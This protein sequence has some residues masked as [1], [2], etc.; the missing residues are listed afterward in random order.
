MKQPLAFL[1]SLSVFFISSAINAQPPQAPN[2]TGAGGK[3]SG[4]W[5]LWLTRNSKPTQNKDSAVY[6]REITYQDGKPSGLVTDFYLTGTKR[7][8]GYLVSDS[9]E[10][11]MSGRAVWYDKD[12]N[13]TEEAQ[14]NRIGKKISSTSFKNLTQ[15]GDTLASLTNEVII[16]NG[17]ENYTK[18][19][20]CLEEC[21]KLAE[22]KFGRQHQVYAGY[23]TLTS[24]LYQTLGSYEKAEPL[25]L[26]AWQIYKTALGENDFACALPMNNLGVLYLNAGK[27]EKAEPLFSQA[28][29]ICNEKQKTADPFYLVCLANLGLLYFEMGQYDKAEPLMLRATEAVYGDFTPNHTTVL[30]NLA[31]LYLSRGRYHEAE[32]LILKATKIARQLHGE[33]HFDYAVTLSS[34]GD[35]YQKVGRY[36]QA[37]PCFE[38]SLAITTSQLG[39]NHI[40]AA[41]QLNRLA[42]FYSYTNHNKEAVPLYERALQII[43]NLIGDT[44]TDYTIF[45][46][47][48][49]KSY[50]DMAKLENAEPLFF[51][52]NENRLNQ[53]DRYFPFLSEK[54]KEEFYQSIKDGFEE[55]LSFALLRYPGN[56]GIT[57]EMYTMQLGTK[58]LLLN[59]SAKWKQ[60]IRTSGDKKLAALYYTW[61]DK[62]AVL[63][64]LYKQ[65]DPKKKPA[66][67]SL[68]RDVNELEKELSRR[69]E[70][71]AQY[72][73]KHHYTWRD[74][75]QKLMPGEAAI[76]ILRIRKYGVTKIVTDSSDASFPRYPKRGI[77]DTVQYAALVLKPGS[78]QPEL[79]VLPNG[80]DLEKHRLN[81]YRN[82]IRN[83][84]RDELSYD[85]FW[86]PIAA[87][88]GKKIRRIYFSPD[89]VYNSINLNTLWNP[90]TNRYLLEEEDIQLLTTS[91]DLLVAKKEED[92]NTLAYLFGYPNYQASKEKRATLVEK[93]RSVQP[94][95]YALAVDRG[96]DLEDLPATKTEV[97]NVASLLTAKGWQPEVLIEDRALEET[98]KEAFKPR[99]LHIATHGYF[100]PD[101]LLSANTN[102]LL[103]SGLMLTGAGRTLAGDKDDNTEDGILTAYEAMNLNLDNTELVVLSACETGLGE[104]RNGEGVYG[105]QRAF[106][107]AGARSIVMSLWKVN[108]EATGELITNFY[109]FWL[110]SGDKRGAFKKAQLSLLAKYPSPYFW[111]AFVMVGE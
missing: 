105:L 57:G 88:L 61:E 51:K 58:A 87:A 23:L 1:L 103:Q 66:I 90:K 109:Q 32:A 38:K 111:G 28:V 85:Q 45:L 62:Q 9:P 22:K 69:S 99:V 18:A 97:E 83:Q 59:S 91:K 11:I 72:A 41:I 60:R 76:E 110:E 79:V 13:K 44:G 50:R 56:P 104:I 74:V 33:N 29:R 30:V 93:E 75:Q 27:Y 12:G 55:F 77:T 36:A 7:W 5:T 86:K 3:R 42:N 92:Y 82:C 20:L 98:L 26:N 37:K 94:V 19:L 46:G 65:A 108:D 34:L 21:L 6:Y 17:H 15:L 47:N 89:G 67:D 107:V 31:E 16:A 25:A 70:A 24:K 35:F 4:P 102:P 39:E 80:N 84:R 54:E 78:K 68:Q 96:S 40:Y 48:L 106:K 52:A 2:K 49:A 71:F 81:Y 43:K 64:K 63:S 95:Y 100:R 73:D 10:D 53:I 8:E 14:F 101:S